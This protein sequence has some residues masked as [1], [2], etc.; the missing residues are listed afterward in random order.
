M[1]LIKD[2][3]TNLF[4]VVLFLLLASLLLYDFG[5]E[6]I[7]LEHGFDIQNQNSSSLFAL[8]T[9]RKVKNSK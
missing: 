6:E 2:F 8:K 7:N 1:H 3:L 5:M 9:D 4:F